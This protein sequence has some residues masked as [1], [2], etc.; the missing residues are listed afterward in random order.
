MLTQRSKQGR[1]A[2]QIDFSEDSR[3]NGRC[4]GHWS[5]CMTFN[6][7]HNVLNRNLE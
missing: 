6:S 3:Q 1:E 7:G 5:P 4:G 2:G